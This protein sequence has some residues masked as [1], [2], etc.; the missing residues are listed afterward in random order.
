M[1]ALKIPDERERERERER[2]VNR[3]TDANLNLEVNKRQ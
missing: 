3:L 1:T 2:V